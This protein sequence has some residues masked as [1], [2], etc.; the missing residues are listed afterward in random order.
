MWG[1]EG[2]IFLA[3]A[4]CV[5]LPVWAGNSRV[6]I[7]PGGRGMCVCVCGIGRGSSSVVLCSLVT[8]NPLLPI[9][10]HFN[11]LRATLHASSIETV[12]YMP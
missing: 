4:L 11:V 7:E 1:V 5:Y 9:P 2:A 6:A 12:D 3:G 8:T 10:K